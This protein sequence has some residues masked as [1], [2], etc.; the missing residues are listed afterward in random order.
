M[1]LEVKLSRRVHALRGVA[2]PL[3]EGQEGFAGNRTRR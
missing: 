2:S 3:L 1:A